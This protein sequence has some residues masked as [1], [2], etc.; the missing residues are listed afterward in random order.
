MLHPVLV[1]IFVKWLIVGIL[2]IAVGAVMFGG[3]HCKNL[4]MD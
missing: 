2:G 1:A 3:E 4:E